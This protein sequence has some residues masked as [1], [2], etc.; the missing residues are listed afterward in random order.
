MKKK[1]IDFYRNDDGS[2]QI[3]KPMSQSP[4]ISS[5]PELINHPKELINLS[6]KVTYREYSYQIGVYDVRLT[7]DGSKIITIERDKLFNCRLENN[8]YVCECKKYF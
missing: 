7:S 2:F 5:L 3:L 4:D 1:I 8:I 6:Y